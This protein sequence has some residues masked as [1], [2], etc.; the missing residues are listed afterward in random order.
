MNKTK[1]VQLTQLKHGGMVAEYMRVRAEDYGL[2]PQQAYVVGLLHDVGFVNGRQDHAT[3]GSNILRAMGLSADF[4][5]AIRLHEISP[6]KLSAPVDDVP[7]DELRSLAEVHFGEIHESIWDN[8]MLTLLLEA[9][10]RVNRYG[11]L[12][13]FDRRKEAL[14]RAFPDEDSRKNIEGQIRYVFEWCDRACI[15]Q[16]PTVAEMK[17][18]IFAEDDAEDD[19]EDAFVSEEDEDDTADNEEEA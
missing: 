16:P 2:D 5:E 1:R 4:C 11:S 10:L 3:T 9:D 6:Y 7:V 13:G 19:A 17:R 15:P 14:F 18:R 8:P 12:I